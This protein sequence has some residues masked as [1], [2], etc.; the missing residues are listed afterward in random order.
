[1]VEDFEHRQDLRALQSHPS[2]HDQPDV[3]RA[4]DHHVFSWNEA[5]DV[6]HFLSEAGRENAG[7]PGPW[8]G[9][10]LTS[11]FPASRGKDD[12]ICRNQE[13]TPGAD[14]GYFFPR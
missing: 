1:M 13:L 10:H 6:D 2:C 12:M 11:S 3:T 4:D 14:E 5:M 8:N 7:R 9:E